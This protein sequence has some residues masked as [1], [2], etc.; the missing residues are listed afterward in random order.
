[1]GKL[2][3]F[4]AAVHGGLY[5]LVVLAVI[6]S[7]IAAYYYV[8]V[9]VLMFMREPDPGQEPAPISAPSALVIA[10]A[11]SGTLLLG[12]FPARLMHVMETAA[13]AVMNATKL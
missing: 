4:S 13:A 2:F 12:I 6:N 9:V 10:L 7:A 5:W 8:R 11:V 1:M 3:L